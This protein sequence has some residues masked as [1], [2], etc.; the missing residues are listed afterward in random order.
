MTEGQKDGRTEGWKDTQT[1][2]S[3]TPI[4]LRFAVVL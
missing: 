1:E 3:L 2:D 4:K